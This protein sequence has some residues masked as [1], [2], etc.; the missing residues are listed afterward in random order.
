MNT[1]FRPFL[2]GV[3]SVLGSV[4]LF[5]SWEVGDKL[6]ELS[7]YGLV[8]EVPSLEGKLTY[9]DFWA[10]WCSPCKASFP[11]IE[12]IY[13]ENKEKGFQ[14]L[15]VSVDASEKAMNRFLDRVKPSFAVVHDAEQAL[16]EAAGVKVMPT[17]YL[18]DGEGVI[19]A[20]HFGWRGGETAKKL[21]AEIAGYLEKSTQ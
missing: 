4:S 15:A 18:V 8:G 19:Q 20:I 2:L 7:G 17:S 11:E 6:P 3:A 10:S 14:V 5:A 13:Q 1:L 9:V 12:R 21:E 16:V